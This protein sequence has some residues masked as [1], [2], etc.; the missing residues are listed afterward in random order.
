VT[1]LKDGAIVADPWTCLADDV[2]LPSEGDVIVSL[3]RLTA[4]P[5]PVRRSG[6]LGVVL[7]NTDP[8]TAVVPYL[9]LI[10]VVALDF[11][12]FTDG[13]AYS[14]ARVLREQCGYTGELR[15]IG[16]VLIDQL[17]F[18]QRCGFDTFEIRGAPNL[19]AWRKAFKA[20]SV[21]YQPTGDERTPVSLLRR[22]LAAATQPAA[23]QTSGSVVSS[24]SCTAAVETQRGTAVSSLP[25]HAP[26]Q[27]DTTSC[28]LPSA[29]SPR[30]THCEPSLSPPSI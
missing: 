20:F 2:P 9:G 24:P 4:G 14:Q 11:P 19:T 1:L 23:R 12:K 8:V 30:S 15:A 16:Q 10:D 22:R 28:A 7:R 26:P 27:S 29:A 13:R 5:P 21:V 17:L 6:R 25:R 3:S 18:M